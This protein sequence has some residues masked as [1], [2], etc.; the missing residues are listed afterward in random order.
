[1]QLP[2]PR[3]GEILRIKDRPLEF[4]FWPMERTTRRYGLG[5]RIFATDPWTVI[6]HSTERRCL[7]S[8]RSAALAFLEQAEDFYRAAESGVKAAKPVLLYY[9]Y[10]NLAKAFL[11]ACRQ[12]GDV[13]NARHGLLEKLDPPPNNIELVNAFL[14][15]VQT[16]PLGAAG[17]PLQNF[18]ELFLAISGVSI[19]GPKRYDLKY[20]MPQIVPGH[21]LWV[22]GDGNNNTERFVS[23]EEIEF[24]KDAATKEIWLRLY[25]F[26]DD[27]K[28][29][30][31]G[32]QEV[33]NRSRLAVLFREVQCNEKRDRRPL[34]CF[35]QLQ[36]ITY[37]HRP[38]DKVPVLI[39][40]VRH[41]LW[42]TVLST[43]PYRKYY[44]YPA[45]T[46]EHGQVVPQILSI[47]AITYYLGS[48]V[49]YRPHHF[50][51]IVAGPYGPFIEAFLND[52]PLQFIYLMASEFAEKEVTKAGIV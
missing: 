12:R 44:I 17:Q 23:I 50:D 35:E 5:T 39:E 46:G 4:S 16:A 27:L 20:L 19:M 36:P 32:H 40:G 48:I 33:L 52:Q 29:V 14:N 28:R 10:M 30:N 15:A 51:K 26:R 47:Y 25:L 24:C 1:M 9:C 3:A 2:Q 37:T 8:T 31:L 38:S 21:R 11:L 41:L 45:P 7:T 34:V 22:E 42:R 6:R 13:N 43:R 49:R 18:D